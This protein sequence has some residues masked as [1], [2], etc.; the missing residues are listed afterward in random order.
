V[1][2]E[3]DAD[4]LA[5]IQCCDGQLVSVGGAAVWGIFGNAYAEDLEIA[6]TR[7]QLR[8]RTSDVTTAGYGTS[9]VVATESYL[10]RGIQPDG[11]GMTTLIL[12]LQS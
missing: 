7:P 6:G 12:E 1:A 5:V 2:I 3:T 8:C 10:V 11:T 9:V 4:R